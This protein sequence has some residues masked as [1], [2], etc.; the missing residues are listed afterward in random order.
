MQQQSENAYSS[1]TSSDAGKATAR[2]FLQLENACR[3]IRWI[4]SSKVTAFRNF[5]RTN[6]CAWI[7][8]ALAGIV[9]LG[10]LPRQQTTLSMHMR[11]DS[12]SVKFAPVTERR[13]ECANAELAIVV[14]ESGRAILARTGQSSRKPTGI[15]VRVEG[16]SKLKDDNMEQKRN[17]QSPMLETEEGT[18]KEAKREQREKADGPILRIDAGDSKT[19]SRSSSQLE[20]QL[21]PIEMTLFGTATKRSR[22]DEAKQ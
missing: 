2:I 21:S 7:S 19:I 12:E 9:M 16:D 20:K 5:R 4:P 3:P 10:G 13:P 11:T 8:R 22:V 17:A 1:M 15:S 14:T 6:A 18:L